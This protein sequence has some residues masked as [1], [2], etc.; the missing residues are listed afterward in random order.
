MSWLDRIR[1]RS[2]RLTEPLPNGAAVYYC[3]DSVFIYSIWTDVYG[4]AGIGD[5]PRKLKRTAEPSLLGQAVVD[6]VKSSRSGIESSYSGQ[7][8][9]FVRNEKKGFRIA[10][11]S[12]W[13][14]LERWQHVPVVETSPGRVM[15]SV[16]QRC[17]S[18]GHVTFKDFPSFE[19]DLTPEHVGEVLSRI[20]SEKPMDDYFEPPSHV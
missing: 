7:P 9:V 15:I 8:D 6:A 13:Y 18:G 17:A 16:T 5:N 14:E 2:E 12:G 20:M 10:G 1:G 3:N 4:R 19:C 11:V